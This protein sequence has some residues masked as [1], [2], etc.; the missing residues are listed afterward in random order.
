MV[1]A[2]I[3]EQ[4][5]VAKELPMWFRPLFDSLKLHP[6]GR[7]R[8][9]RRPSGPRLRLEALEERTLLSFSPAANYAVAANPLDVVV[10]DFNGDGKADLA[11]ING[12]QVSVLPGNGDGTFGAAQTTAAGSGLR[13]AAAGDFNGDRRLDL[14]ITS[15]VWNGTANT[16]SV[17]VLLNSTAVAGGPVTFQAARSFGTGTNLT[18][19]A[20]AVGDLNGDGKADVAAA[21][22]GGGNVSV[23][24][25]DGAGNLGAARQVAVG[26][27]PVSVAVG[28]LDGDVDGRLDLVTANQGS[29]SVS[30]LL[31]GGND[32]AGDAQF[33]PARNAAVSYGSPTSAAVGDF[34]N[35]G[36]LDLAVSS[37]ESYYS[38]GCS[39]SGYWCGGG[40]IINGYV[41]VLLGH[42]DGTFDPAR[43]QWLNSA[44]PGEL[45]TGDFNGDG[46][47]DVALLDDVLYG[48]TD[49][50]TVLLGKGDGTF[51]AVYHY[52]GGSGPD[53]VAVGHFNGDAFPDVAVAN[54]YSGNVSVLLN[55]T[56][57]RTL[58]VSGLPASTAAGQAQAFTVTVLDNA[59]NVQ[60]GYTGTMH[61][62]SGDPRADLP[63]DYQFTA[64]DAGVHTFSV[65]FKTAGW[66]GVLARD[67]A[68]PNLAGSGS[69]SVTP[70]AVSTLLIDGFPSPTSA[71]D[72]GYFTVTAYDTYGNVA[73][74]YAGTVHF[75]SSDGQA[76]LPDDY[77]F[78]E[79]DYGTGYF[80]AALQTVGTQS[81]T[82]T[83]LANPSLTATQS[84]IRV[85]P[86]AT[87]S[88]PYAGLRNQTLTF[89]LGATSG[90]P[91]GTV[92]TYA[93]DWNYDG[94][95]DQTVSGPSGT[96]VTHSYADG[97]W[98]YVGV[99]ATAHIGAEDYTSYTAYQGLTIFAVT[100]AV[101]ADPGDAGKSALVVEGT[102]DYDYLTLS[103]AAGNAIALSVSG[104]SVGSFSAPGGAAFAH[105]LVYGYGGGD[106][107]Y[108]TGGLAVPA[109]LF[110]GDGDDTLD[111]SGSIA[112]NVLAG[113]AGNDYLSG[114]SGRDLLAGGLGADA[115]RAGSG[116]AILIGGYTDYDANV[117][118]LLAVMKEWGRTDAD[119]TTR[120]KHLNG[121]LSGGLNG[122]YRLTTTT[123]HNDNAIDNLYGGAG[124]DWFFVG[125]RGKK[126]DKVY[127]RASGEVTT[128]L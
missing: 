57:W 87:V 112:N 4:A 49:G 19:G 109:L 85:L 13:S 23:L 118:A 67:T 5:T 51:K 120:I 70:G 90:L 106:S 28:D 68:A 40:W 31:N 107:I 1:A 96:T 113:G 48:F 62:T 64:A 122:S 14:A 16:G 33:Q 89:T 41:H 26:S 9:P 124:L 84:G 102:A 123:V 82:V 99:T 30:V 35:D 69:I 20:V 117:Q 105:L 111:A 77:T 127:D 125:G 59:G 80:Y 83:D 54:N 46:K 25:G 100:V 104:Y 36:K 37:Q 116:G 24:R 21:E 43:T 6:A 52:Y 56:D 72:Y 75:T 71:G 2:P 39:P 108:L 58:V 42:G 34:D 98:Y 7:G 74:N 45:A 86:S 44:A 88:G 92:F 10:G 61:F 22:A 32:A 119:Y 38:G 50:S 8:R 79:W 66:Q 27:N 94:V 95:V 78:S 73:T 110:G 15:S 128:T 18:P 91:A 115:L 65:T 11:T 29:G 76:L 121:T 126:K 47:L 53:A 60:T 101:Q 97:G 63:A 55:D 17:L 81:L 12:T 3:I 114:G 93:I 103:P